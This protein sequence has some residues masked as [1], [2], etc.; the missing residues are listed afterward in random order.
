MLTNQL[1]SI[2]KMTLQEG[3]PIDNKDAIVAEIDSLEEQH[4]RLRGQF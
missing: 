4:V 3:L 2:L 1:L